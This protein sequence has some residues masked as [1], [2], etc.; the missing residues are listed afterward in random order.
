MQ[1]TTLQ[2]L[3]ILV[4]SNKYNPDYVTKRD[5]Y[6]LSFTD[7]NN[8]AEK[9]KNHVYHIVVID[10][11]YPLELPKILTALKSQGNGSIFVCGYLDNKEELYAINPNLFFWDDQ[12]ENISLEKVIQLTKLK[13]SKVKYQVE[14]K[15]LKDRLDAQQIMLAELE[16][17]NSNLI[18]ATWR[19]RDMKQ[20]LKDA[21][22]EI[23]RSKEIIEKQNLRISE[24]INYA[25]KIQLAINPSEFDLSN[26]FDNSFILY[27]PKDVI[28]GD[29]PWFYKQGEYIYVAAVDCTGH[30]VPGAMLSMIGNLL[31]NDI[32]N[33]E[34]N[35]LPSQILH[36]LHQA[37]IRTLKQETSVSN[38]NDGMDIGLCRI[39]KKSGQLVFSGAHRPLFVLGSNGIKV[40]DGDKFPI[41]GLHYKG[42]NN[43]TDQVY[44][45]SPGESVFLFTDGFPDQV[46]EETKKKLMSKN[47]KAFIESQAS[48]PFTGMSSSLHQFY[49][50]WKGNQKQID[51]ILV[52]GIQL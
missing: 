4:V 25:R 24:S 26:H 52:I 9:V 48:F 13:A 17:T 5:E 47:L 21:M 34:E 28:S 30:G 7:K 40:L 27:K 43:Y 16:Q 33:D 41:G 11:S 44:N 50:S 29:F 37:V 51:D 18:S 22:D 49:N 12:F 45:Y 10:G 3:E 19:E 8:V 20:K 1:N 6:V 46:G 38:S 39:H 15:S 14:N 42:K 31:L 2:P 23:N 32:I 35:K 36:K